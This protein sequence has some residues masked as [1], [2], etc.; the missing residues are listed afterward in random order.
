MLIDLGTVAGDTASAAVGIDDSGNVV[1]TSGATNSFFWRNG[2]AI[3]LVGDAGMARARAMNHNGRTV[4]AVGGG[5]FGSGC[6]AAWDAPSPVPTPFGAGPAIDALSLTGVGDNGAPFADAR[7]QRG[8]VS[9]I[10]AVTWAPSLGTATIDLGT[11]DGV[12]TTGSHAAAVNSLGQVVGSSGGHAV[13][14]TPLIRDLGNLGAA[15]AAGV[16]IND[17]TEVAGISATAGGPS[18]A[19]LWRAGVMQDLGTLTP[20]GSSEAV[21]LNAAGDVVGNS[22]GHAVLWRAGATIDLGTLGGASSSAVAINDAGQ[23]TGN[24]Q[25]AAGTSHAFL[26]QG[27]VMTDLGTLGGPDSSAKAINA[28]G[29]VAGTSTTGS[30]ASRAF[31]TCP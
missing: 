8:C 7:V 13:I 29:R 4:G 25:T 27:G 22:S 30:G 6:F 12:S 5:C 10:H 15:S 17:A 16:D 20:G 11:I 9:C 1:A 2:M 18:H 24:S 26:W 3:P 28:S 14:W 31:V 21:A 19:F 23:V